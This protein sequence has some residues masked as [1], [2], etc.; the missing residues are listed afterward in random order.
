MA[1]RQIFRVVLIGEGEDLRV[2]GPATVELRRRALHERLGREPKPYAGPPMAVVQ[3][4]TD[5]ILLVQLDGQHWL[6]CSRCRQPLG[7]ASENYKLHCHRI[8][9]PI[10]AASTLIGE[11]LRFI[12]EPVQF[13]QFCCPACGALIEN[14]VCRAADPVLWDIELTSC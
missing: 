3:Q 4:I 5:Q 14:E 9:H 10:Q 1:A 7:P 8:D 11:P 2:D 12:D 6:V 13:R